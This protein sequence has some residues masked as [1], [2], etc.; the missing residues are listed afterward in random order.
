MEWYFQLWISFSSHDYI[1]VVQGFA[2][3]MFY[4][5]TWDV[6]EKMLELWLWG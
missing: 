3:I 4:P 5:G 6:V 2:E 1:S